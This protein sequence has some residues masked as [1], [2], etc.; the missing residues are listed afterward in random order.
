MHSLPEL[1]QLKQHVLLV[2]HPDLNP[3]LL[4]QLHHVPLLA[5]VLVGLAKEDSH[6]APARE[7]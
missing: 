6:A 7:E 1:S 2:V 5:A 4:Q 3:I